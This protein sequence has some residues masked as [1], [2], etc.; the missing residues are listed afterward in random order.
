MYIL[1]CNYKLLIDFRENGK[2]S[3]KEMAA[4]WKQH[5]EDHKAYLQI[6]DDLIVKKVPD[7]INQEKSNE[8]DASNK[9]SWFGLWSK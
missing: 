4:M 8:V 1:K 9:K 5:I 7:N 2:Y 6:I 3:A